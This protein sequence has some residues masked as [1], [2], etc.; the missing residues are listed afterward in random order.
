MA[1]AD[2]YETNVIFSFDKF[3]KKHGYKLVSDSQVLERIV[4]LCKIECYEKPQKNKTS[5]TRTVSNVFG[6][7]EKQK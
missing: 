3:Y 2:L 4:T 6:R 7:E 5:R 1:I